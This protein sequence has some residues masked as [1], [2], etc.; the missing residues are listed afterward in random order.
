MEKQKNS[1]EENINWNNIA[2]AEPVI[3]SIRCWI[4]TRYFGQV[5]ISCITDTTI[6]DWQVYATDLHIRDGQ[7]KNIIIAIFNF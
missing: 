6:R 7:H 5:R 2:K 3:I 4:E 1:T